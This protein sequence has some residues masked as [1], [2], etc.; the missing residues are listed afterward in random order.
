MTKA[1]GAFVYPPG[2]R[3]GG[4]SGAYPINTRGRAY[5]ALSYAGQKR[6]KG[7]YA[8]VEKAVNRR[9]PDIQTKHH[10]PPRGSGRRR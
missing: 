7:S 8:T 3:T 1:R 4:K 5:A 6:T 9:Y 2:T 10:M